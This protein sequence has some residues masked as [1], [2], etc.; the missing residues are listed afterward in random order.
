MSVVAKMVLNAMDVMTAT[1]I[2]MQ[3]DLLKDIVFKHVNSAMFMKEIRII[4]YKATGHCR[5]NR[6]NDSQSHSWTNIHN[7]PTT[8]E[9]L[10]L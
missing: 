10:T 4:I 1:T 2:Q 5:C 8:Q 9:V 3:T 6:I 7:I